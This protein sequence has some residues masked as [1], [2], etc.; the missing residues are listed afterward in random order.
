[1]YPSMKCEFMVERSYDFIELHHGAKEIYKSSIKL[2]HLYQEHIIN[3]YKVI[4]HLV[5]FVV[6]VNV[7]MN[8]I[9]HNYK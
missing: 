9:I 1:M 3:N 6:C 7:N 2:S 4:F 5:M 8:E